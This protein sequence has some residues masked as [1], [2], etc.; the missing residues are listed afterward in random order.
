MTDYSDDAN[1]DCE[2][3][4]LVCRST[5]SRCTTTTVHLK[6]NFC[7]DS[8]NGAH[9][10]EEYGHRIVLSAS[11]IIVDAETV[12]S[13]NSLYEGHVLWE[14][15]MTMGCNRPKPKDGGNGDAATSAESVRRWLDDAR[16]ALLGQRDGD[17]SAKPDGPKYA[18][19]L[20][21][22]GDDFQLTWNMA[23]QPFGTRALGAV[24]LG[25]PATTAT[26]AELTVIRF[27]EP[28]IRGLLAE[29][30]GHERA[31][32]ESAEH[33]KRLLDDNR[34]LLE[35]LSSAAEGR[36]RDDRRLMARF[37]EVLNAKKRQLAVE[38]E[39]MRELQR[40]FLKLKEKQ[41]SADEKT[42]EEPPADRRQFGRGKGRGGRD[43]NSVKTER[44]AVEVKK[45]RQCARHFE[46]FDSSS[47]AFN[48]EE[49]EER[50]VDVA[51]Q[52]VKRDDDDEERLQNPSSESMETE[53]SHD[54]NVGNDHCLTTVSVL[55]AAD[56]PFAVDTQLDDPFAADTQL[57][58][59]FAAET[60]LD[61]PFANRCEK[62][63]AETMAKDQAVVRCPTATTL[64]SP[65]KDYREPKTKTTFDDLWSGIL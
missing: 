38:R 54:T 21:R 48:R 17:G 3:A 8:G 26:D 56:D 37:V 61:N 51:V 42:P 45:R 22:D 64:P 7:K 39:R 55:N 57:D 2:Y 40:E 65:N 52:P 62:R 36:Q 50:L 15:A 33:S 14:Q 34:R 53:G 30:R 4:T 43:R 63:P 24:R 35:Q 28:L 1:D 11:A 13:T 20:K 19:G 23:L 9:D 31:D 44:V 27:V 16:A 29:R 10:Y 18:Y 41:G 59:P 12:S 58:D 6:L 25:R 60:Q 49:D 32:R 5:T 46:N 47:F